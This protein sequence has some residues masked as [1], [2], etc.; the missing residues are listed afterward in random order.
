MF[1]LGMEF[2]KAIP[3]LLLYIAPLTP[4]HNYL[5]SWNQSLCSLKSHCSNLWAKKRDLEFV[6]SEN[7]CPTEVA[8]L[9]QQQ[10]A[11]YIGCTF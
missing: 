10:G 8:I 11:Y 7:T 2:L 1:W 5:S 9:S 3:F 4:V 6:G